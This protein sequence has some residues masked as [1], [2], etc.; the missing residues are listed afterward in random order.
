M[1]EQRA[2][3][4][5]RFIRWLFGSPF[6]QLPPPFG[7][8]V[9]LDLQQFEAEADDA[10]RQGFGGVAGQASSHHAKSSPARGD[11]SLERQ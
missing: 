9:P 4:P 7:N 10:Q 6:R 1:S 3:W 2:S 8:P 5:K 11:E